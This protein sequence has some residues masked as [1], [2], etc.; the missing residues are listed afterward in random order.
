MSGSA[1]R[2]GTAALQLGLGRSVVYDLLK[3]YRQRSQTSSL[4]PGKRGRE[5]KV[6][7]LK[8]V[9]EQLLSSRWLW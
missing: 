4:L 1:L 2:A 8:Q 9:H 6:P 5:P 7:V 3:R